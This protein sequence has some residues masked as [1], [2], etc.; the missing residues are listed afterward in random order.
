M[1]HVCEIHGKPTH[2]MKLQEIA[3]VVREWC[4]FQTYDVCP[5][6]VSQKLLVKYW[7]AFSSHS[8]VGNRANNW[9]L[10]W[11]YKLPIICIKVKKTSLSLFYF[12][13]SNFKM[14]S[15]VITRFGKELVFDDGALLGRILKSDMSPENDQFKQVLNQP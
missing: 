13:P 9:Y 11:L 5:R 15:T 10:R 1:S 3:T 14:T 2:K 12:F 4:L 6:N 8:A 7:A